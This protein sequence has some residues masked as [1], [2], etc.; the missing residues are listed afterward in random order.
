MLGRLE[1]GLLLPFFI[2]HMRIKW[3]ELQKPVV[4][5]GGPPSLSRTTYLVHAKCRG[6]LKEMRFYPPPP[7]FILYIWELN[8]RSCRTLQ[9]V[10]VDHHLSL[11]LYTLFMQIAGEPWRRFAS[12]PFFI[13]YIK[14]SERSFINLQCVM[15]DH[16]LS[17]LLYTL[18][19]QNAWAP[20]RRFASPPFFILYIKVSER[21]LIT[22]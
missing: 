8:E 14:V 1:G 11:L 13:L 3:K 17:L 2:L 7:F 5:H 19:M 20:W 21:S 12:P 22:L 16:H 6:A 4:C 10:M 18:F 15:V 9:C